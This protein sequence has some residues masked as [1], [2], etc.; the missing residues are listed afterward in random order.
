MGHIKKD[1]GPGP[2]NWGR[3]TNFKMTAKISKNGYLRKSRISDKSSRL[4]ENFS[5]SANFLAN[6]LKSLALERY[7]LYLC[8]SSP[9]LGLLYHF[10]VP[11]LVQSQKFRILRY[12]IFQRAHFA[13][14]GVGPKRILDSKTVLLYSVC[15]N[16]FQQ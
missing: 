6:D 9:K 1:S 4:K 10:K 7:E 2:K 3:G 5:S 11:I 16:F 8:D 15:P 13:D 12:S 14:P